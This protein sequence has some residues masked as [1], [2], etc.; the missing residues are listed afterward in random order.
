VKRLSFLDIAHCFSQLVHY[1]K[2][3]DER[4]REHKDHGNKTIYKTL[5]RLI[6]HRKLDA[7]LTL[8]NRAFK[9]DFKEKFLLRAF[10][11]S[12]LYRMKHYFGKWK[13]NND[14]MALAEKIN[15]SNL[16]DF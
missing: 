6:K 8:R 1:K 4:M 3:L 7:L 11:H 9:K 16:K 12:L 15:V 5:N 2:S 10:K 13:H 14:R